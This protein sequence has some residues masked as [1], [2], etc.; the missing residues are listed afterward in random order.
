LNYIFLTVRRPVMREDQT[1][2]RTLP[3]IRYILNPAISGRHLPSTE[4]QTSSGYLRVHHTHSSVDRE[5]L[6]QCCSSASHFDADPDPACHSGPDLD[7]DPARNFEVD[8]DHASH[9]DE[10]PNPDPLLPF[11]LMWVRIQ[12]LAS[13]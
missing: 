4:S 1:A 7:P 3:G 11:T 2:S 13:E 5:P 8:P 12:I 10:D 9:F 6:Q